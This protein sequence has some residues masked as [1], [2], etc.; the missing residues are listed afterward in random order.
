MRFG[1]V[2]NRTYHS[3]QVIPILKNDVGN[4]T[5]TGITRTEFYYKFHEMRWNRTQTKSLCYIRVIYN[6]KW[7]NYGLDYKMAKQGN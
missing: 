7:Y 2:R 5:P 1:M 6:Q 4:L 3:V